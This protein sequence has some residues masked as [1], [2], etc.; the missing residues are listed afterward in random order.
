M[1]PDIAQATIDVWFAADS[2]VT[3]GKHRSHAR[4]YPIG[5]H[6]PMLAGID[7]LVLAGRIR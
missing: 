2:D 4:R 6:V 5:G 1:L 3:T 7:L